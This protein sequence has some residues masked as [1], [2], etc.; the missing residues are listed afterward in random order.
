MSPLNQY[1]YIM[2]NEWDTFIQ[3]HTTPQVIAVSNKMKALHAKNKFRHKLEPGGYKVAMPKWAKKEQELH[4]AG[5]SDPLEGCTMH[6]R[7]RIWGHSR[8]DDSGRLITSKSEV[9]SVVEKAKT[10]TAKWKTSEF[11]SQRE[12]DQLN[13]ALKNEEHHGR[14]QA[15]SSIASWNAGFL[16]ESHQYKKC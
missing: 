12:R 5:I 13:V 10:L 3:Q 7:N 11:K 6:T 9:T 8:I 1:G 2:P 4:D 16:D 14:T 15:I